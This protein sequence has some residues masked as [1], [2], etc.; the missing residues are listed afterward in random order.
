M[1]FKKLTI[2]VLLCAVG[3][4]ATQLR[5]PRKGP[6]AAKTSNSGSLSSDMTLSSDKFKMPCGTFTCGE[7]GDKQ[8]PPC[9]E[10]DDDK[11]KTPC[12][13]FTC[14]PNGDKQCPP[15]PEEEEEKENSNQ[16]SEKS[17]KDAA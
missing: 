17:A 3:A 8:C 16:Q 12:G 5:G 7:N 14:G 10:D 11:F 15:C 13:T 4:S 1:A 9:P 2:F 6:S